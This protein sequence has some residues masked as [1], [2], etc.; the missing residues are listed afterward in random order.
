LSRGAKHQKSENV[1]DFDTKYSQKLLKIVIKTSLELYYH[2]K[3][4]QA[5]CQATRNEAV[6]SAFDCARKISFILENKSTLSRSAKKSVQKLGT[7][8]C[9]VNSQFQVGGGTRRLRGERHE[10]IN[11]KN[12]RSIDPGLV[13]RPAGFYEQD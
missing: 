10:K 1:G 5:K 3:S 12:N 8:S 4:M 11:R 9:N 2:I 13:L 7:I 6:L